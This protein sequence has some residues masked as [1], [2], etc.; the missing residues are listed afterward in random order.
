MGYACPV[1]ETPQADGEHL[2]NHLA[3]TALLHGGGHESWLDEHVDGWNDLRPADLADQVTAL[4]ESTDYPTVFE[5]TTGKD[6][7]E[8]HASPHKEKTA[9]PDLDKLDGETRRIVEEALELSQQARDD[10]GAQEE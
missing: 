10:A 1:C 7:R 5:D 4:A 3:F 9:T 2:A 6:N 8:E